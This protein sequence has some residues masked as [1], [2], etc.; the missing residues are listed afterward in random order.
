M[1]MD[2][3]SEINIKPKQVNKK[4]KTE[5]DIE[6]LNSRIR[7]SISGIADTICKSKLKSNITP[8]YEDFSSSVSSLKRLPNAIKS[9]SY[10]DLKSF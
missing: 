2:K 8:H 1:M 9:H 7:K 10:K 4:L 5:S 6:V 3:K